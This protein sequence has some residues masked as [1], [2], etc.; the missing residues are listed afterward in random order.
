MTV[1]TLGETMLRLSPPR[2]ERLSGADRL[3]LTLGGA[4]S[5]VAVALAALGLPTR[6]LGAVPSNE[7][8]DRVIAEL[9]AT[10]VDVSYVV[11]RDG[12]R[13]GLYFVELP[14]SPRPALVLYD[15]RDAAATHMSADDLASGALDDASHAVVSGITAALKPHGAELAHAFF[16]RA[17]ERGA[18]RILDVN[19]RRQLWQ[20]L[21]A[22]DILMGLAHEA[23]VL[24]CSAEDA[25]TL[26]G[27]GQPHQDVTTA[28]RELAPNAT[29]VVVTLGERGAIAWH[30]RADALSAESAAVEVVDPFG[31]GDA[32]V[33]GVIWAELEGQTPEGQLAAGVALAG[34]A[35]TVRGDHARFDAATLQAVL[36]GAPR[37]ALR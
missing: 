3:D 1:V 21:E 35:C 10:G 25:R 12:G 6:W 32:L 8:G 15:R 11:R 20:P 31:A 4:E 19:F 5:N 2:G 16:A 26:F 34:L 36:A 13:L 18:R 22:A 30:A 9:S 33:A 24:F 14:V 27:F 23:D 29:F 28:L 17:G 37:K 7:L